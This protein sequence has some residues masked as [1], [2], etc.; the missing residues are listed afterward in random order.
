MGLILRRIRKKLIP[1]LFLT[2]ATFSILLTVSWAKPAQAIE[3][4][5]YEALTFPP[6]GDIV[7]PDYERYELDNGLVVYLMEDHDLPLVGGSATFRT[8][9]YLVPPEKT[10][11]AG[12]TGQAM[13]L[14]GT[15]THSPEAINEMLEQRA[16]SVETSIGNTSGSASFSALTEDL[17]TVFDLFAEVITQPAFDS[18]QFDLIKSRSAGSI[19]RRNDDPD[20]IVSREFRKLVY[21]D[22]SPYARVVEYANLNSISLEDVKDFYESTLTPANTILGIVGDFDPDVMKAQ[23]ERTLGQWESA[24]SVDLPAPP[25]GLQQQAGLF[26]VDQPQLTQSYVHV[27]HIGDELSS[28]DHASMVVLNEVLN[29][30]GGRLFN[31]IRSRQG[32]AYSVYAVWSPRYDHNGLF[33]GGGQTRSETTVPFI[34]S[35][36]TEIEKIRNEPVS[37]TELAFA[38]DS[39]LN[40]F[41]FNF[42]TPSQTLSR[43]IRYEFYDYPQD[44]VFQYRDNVERTTAQA[45]LSAAQANL[46][47]DQLI[48]VVV[49]NT[50]DI[51]PGL[52]TLGSEMTALDVTIPE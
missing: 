34:Q 12:I 50:A 19:A 6:L 52:E 9:S 2:V 20:D 24:G 43:V 4:K 15:L 48:T 26:M 51:Q 28:P 27:G 25:E 33:I 29:G 13:R 10:G 42:Q 39:V 36:Y 23:I 16:A 47:P 3:A 11:L 44:F 49:G 17:E 31:E 18:T 7:I 46:T 1:L 40:S 5:P 22:E 8:G 14:G 38:K 37:E 21:G 32:L 35:I 30:F 45:V 41:V